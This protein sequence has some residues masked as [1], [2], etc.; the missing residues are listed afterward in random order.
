MFLDNKKTSP[1]AGL[2]KGTINQPTRLIGYNAKMMQKMC[3]LPFNYTPKWPKIP[4]LA[5]LKG[6]LRA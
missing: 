6:C 1:L 2:E 4:F 5:L 3:S